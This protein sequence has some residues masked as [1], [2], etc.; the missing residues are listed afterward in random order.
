MSVLL[1][2]GR[3]YAR[4]SRPM[5]ERTWAWTRGSTGRWGLC[6]AVLNSM[7]VRGANASFFV[8]DVDCRYVMA[9]AFHLGIYDLP[10]E[11][12]L[13][14]RVASD[15]FPDL[16]AQAYREHRSESMLGREND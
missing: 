13:V 8:K 5:A 14:G 6:L 3:L 11:E 1:F 10:R 15:F 2:R 7:R 4:R 16:L 12:N 9:N